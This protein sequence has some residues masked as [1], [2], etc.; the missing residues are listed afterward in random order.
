MRVAPRERGRHQ[1]C[2]GESFDPHE[3]FIAGSRTR[4]RRTATDAQCLHDSVRHPVVLR[5]DD[6]AQR[7][8]RRA[9]HLLPTAALLR[10][11]ERMA[12]RGV[13]RAHPRRAR[14]RSPIRLVSATETSETTLS[15][16]TRHGPPT[17]R[18][19]RCVTAT[20]REPL[21]SPTG[22]PRA[23]EA[24]QSSRPACDAGTSDRPPRAVVVVSYDCQLGTDHVAPP[25]LSPALARPVSLFP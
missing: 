21:S 19:T 13:W 9:L 25:G 14:P 12:M 6:G 4:S 17:S 15:A 11:H 1:P 23:D 20:P 8:A 2:S 24:V 22:C 16:D 7:P 5:P 18:S 10:F 3:R